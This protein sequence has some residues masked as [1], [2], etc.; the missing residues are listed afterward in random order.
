LDHIGIIFSL[1]RSRWARSNNDG[2]HL[3]PQG[4]G[5]AHRAQ[6]PGAG[7]GKQRQTRGSV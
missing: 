2:H 5:A 1:E 3:L 7:T 4:S 6:P